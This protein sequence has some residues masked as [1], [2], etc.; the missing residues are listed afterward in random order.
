MYCTKKMDVE[1]TGDAQF[2]SLINR[3]LIKLD[4]TNSITVLSTQ[5]IDVLVIDCPYTMIFIKTNVTSFKTIAIKT[6]QRLT[7]SDLQDRPLHLPLLETCECG[8][9][10]HCLFDNPKCIN[11]ANASTF[12]MTQKG[13]L[14]GCI[15]CQGIVK[16]ETV[17]IINVRKDP[18]PASLHIECDSLI[19]KRN[20]PAGHK[21][22]FNDGFVPNITL[23]AVMDFFDALETNELIYEN[24]VPFRCDI[25]YKTLKWNHIHIA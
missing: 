20:L 19:I 7:L 5:S 24:I 16:A 15:D 6:N 12:N 9:L 8:E 18:H 14:I 17:N 3:L 25:K 1:I 21:F 4:E 2:T 11:I 10:S 22:I 23:I 13:S